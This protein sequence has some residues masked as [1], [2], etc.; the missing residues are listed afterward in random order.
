ML[1]TR[2][3]MVNDRREQL[4]TAYNK[5]AGDPQLDIVGRA[6]SGPD[7]FRKIQN[8]S[9]DL[10]LLELDVSGPNAI[11][12]FGDP[13]PH[14]IAGVAVHDRFYRLS[15]GELDAGAAVT[16]GFGDSSLPLIARLFVLGDAPRP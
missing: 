15:L 3:L 16:L 5:L 8:L 10:V 12:I 11:R 1:P 7:A 4:H 14:R 2:I 6:H 9:P 13:G